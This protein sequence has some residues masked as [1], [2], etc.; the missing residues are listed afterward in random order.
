[1]HNQYIYVHKTVQRWAMEE[2]ER[3]MIPHWSLS[4][5]AL[6]LQSV[7]WDGKDNEHSIIYFETQRSGECLRLSLQHLD[8][9]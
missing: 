4:D 6:L 3:K 1:M 7:E 2:D 8:I 5:Y 9:D